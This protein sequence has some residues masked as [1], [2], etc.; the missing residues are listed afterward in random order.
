MVP[1]SRKLGAGRGQLL[2]MLG[3]VPPL[4]PLPPLGLGCPGPEGLFR[5]RFCIALLSLVPSLT[6]PISA[7]SSQRHF[8]SLPVLVCSCDHRIPASRAPP[9]PGVPWACGPQQIPL[10]WRPLCHCWRQQGGCRPASLP[11]SSRGWG[12][13]SSFN[14]RALLLLCIFFENTLKYTQPEV[15]H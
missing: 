8:C 1:K 10:L 2:L 7:R 6:C 11:S 12:S 14:L 4:H 15:D 9:H 5:P 13:P 3:C